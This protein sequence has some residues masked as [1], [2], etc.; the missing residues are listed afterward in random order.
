M[1][2]A[3]DGR[4]VAEDEVVVDQAEGL[5]AG[6]EFREDRGSLF[7]DLLEQGQVL[8]AEEVLDRSGV[9]GR[10]LGGE[11]RRGIPRRQ[12]ESRWG[13]VVLGGAVEV[14]GGQTELVDAAG[15]E[16]AARSAHLA[17]DPGGQRC[18]CGGFEPDRNE[19]VLGHG[20]SVS[21]SRWRGAVHVISSE[22]RPC[23]LSAQ[24]ALL[25]E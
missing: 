13:R 21:G 9:V 10:V 8:A 7:G 25:R 6:A 12:R 16:S 23:G 11:H 4:A 20:G 14:G 22:S 18:G 1:G 5:A 24:R 3:A 15:A 17:V 2:A 19:V